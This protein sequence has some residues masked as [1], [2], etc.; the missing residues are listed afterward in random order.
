MV[1]D[2]TAYNEKG[3]AVLA[4]IEV[5]CTAP[6]GAVLAEIPIAT[7]TTTTPTTTMRPPRARP[8]GDED[9]GNQGAPHG[10]RHGSHEHGH[11][12]R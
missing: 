8:H 9:Q 1:A 11:H 2:A 3:E 12:R 10:E 4:P 7:A 6:A 5:D